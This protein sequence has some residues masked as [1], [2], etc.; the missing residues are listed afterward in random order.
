MPRGLRIESPGA[1]HHVYAR[2]NRK[3]AIYRDERDR[4]IYLKLLGAAVVDHEWRCLAYCLMSNHVHLLVETPRPNLGAGVQQLHG[5]YARIFNKRHELTGHLFRRPYGN[6]VIRTD[7]QL[8][9]AV[10]YVAMNPVAAG[11]SPTPDR[12]RWGSCS[13]RPQWVDH[14]R[15]LEYLGAGGGDPGKRYAELTGINSQPASRG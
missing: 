13:A 14:A 11:L 7:E 1:I 10:R 4:L 2:G 5:G 6:T 9:A 8:C 12:W 3:Q 15:L